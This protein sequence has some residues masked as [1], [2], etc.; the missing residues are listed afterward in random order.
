MRIPLIKDPEKLF[1][2][3]DTH[4][5]HANIIKYCNRPYKDVN[6]MDEAL[7]KN[8]NA[9]VPVDAIVYHLGD[10]AFRDAGGYARRLNGKIRLIRGNHDHPAESAYYEAVGRKNETIATAPF[11]SLDDVSWV[12]VEGNYIW[13]SH[14]AHRVWPHQGRKSWHLY[15]HS[16]NNLPEDQSLSFDVGVD[17]TNYIPMSYAEVK[18][19]IEKKVF[20][21]PPDHHGK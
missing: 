20:V 6:E 5:G 3:S 16:H 1:F 2:T 9:K 19:K 18:A 21:K 17:C 4:F 10:F 15:G 8:W 7:I 14:Y 13:L 12:T 11:S